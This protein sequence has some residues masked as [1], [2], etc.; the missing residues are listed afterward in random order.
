MTVQ[1]KAALR[2][3]ENPAIDEKRKVRCYMDITCVPSIQI[4]NNLKSTVISND[5]H[6]LKLNK[7]LLR[8]WATIT[9]V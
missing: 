2:V 7:R 3:R 4:P 6:E 8:I 9:I 5:K 1:K